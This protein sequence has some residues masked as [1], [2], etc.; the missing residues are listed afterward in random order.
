MALLTGKVS[1]VEEETGQQVTITTSI[2]E[3]GHPSKVKQ[4][5]QSPLFRIPPEVRNHIFHFATLPDYKS[6]NLYSKHGLRH[7]LDDGIVQKYHTSLLLTCRL[8]WLETNGLPLRWVAHHFYFINVAN[9]DLLADGEA[10][11]E[12]FEANVARQEVLWRHL[13]PIGRSNLQHIH[14]HTAVTDKT[15]TKGSV[16]ADRMLGRLKTGLQLSPPKLLTLTVRHHDWPRER[17][18]HHD[19]FGIERAWDWSVSHVMFLKLLFKGLCD[20]EVPTF[21]LVLEGDISQ[22]KNLSA[23][24]E[25][26]KASMAVVSKFFEDESPVMRLQIPVEERL[27]LEPVY[28]ESARGTGL[29]PQQES[30]EQPERADGVQLVDQWRLGGPGEEL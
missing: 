6:S 9:P 16:W 17:E 3:V 11:T 19:D 7:A 14:Y 10:A 1:R 4:Q 25:D 15:G 29:E 26:L 28:E 12:I 8:I 5:L 24:M 23:V 30:A 18:R 2:A 27:W 22:A 20:L 13:T 21:R